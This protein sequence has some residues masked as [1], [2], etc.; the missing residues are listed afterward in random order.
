MNLKSLV[1]PSW[2]PSHPSWLPSPTAVQS[3]DCS[4]LEVDCNLLECEMLLRPTAVGWALLGVAAAHRSGQLNRRRL[5]EVHS[6]LLDRPMEDVLGA[7]Q[8]R[9]SPLCAQQLW[10]C[11][12]R[13]KILYVLPMPQ[14]LLPLLSGVACLLQLLPPAL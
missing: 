3:T 10:L 8:A 11:A 14:L 9:H 6:T 4:L 13:W 2:L 7:W 5:L 12:V 1:L